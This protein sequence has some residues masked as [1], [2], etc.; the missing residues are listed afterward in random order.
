MLAAAFALAVAALA[1]IGLKGP[2][3][4]EPAQVRRF[5]FSPGPAI[6]RPGFRPIISPDGRFIAYSAGGPDSLLQIRALGD[7]KPSAL[8]DT[9]GAYRPL[10]S[11]D[12][13]TIAFRSGG[14]LKRVSVYGG[15]VSVICDLP[16]SNF[17]GAVWHPTKD[18]IVFSS[19]V[20]P[21]LY[22][23]DAAGGEPEPFGDQDR[24]GGASLFPHFISDG[25][26]PVGIAYSAGGPANQEIVVASLDGSHRV[27]LGP[28]SYPWYDPDGYLLFQSSGGDEGL[29]AQPFSAK[30]LEP[31]GGAVPVDP[32]GAAASVSRD[33]TLV[34]SDA[35]A[36]SG[37]SQLVWLDRTG[38]AT[39][40]IGM[41]EPVRILSIA[42]SPDERYVAVEAVG[43]GAEDIWV[44]DS[45]TSTRVRLTFEDGLSASPVWDPAGAR[46]A[47]RR[48]REGNADIFAR[49]FDRSS[50]AEALLATAR[51]EIPSSFAPDGRSLVYTVS[52]E[53]TRYD[54]WMIENS[55]ETPRPLLVAP[56][57]EVSPA[58]SPDGRWLAFCSDEGGDYEVHVQPFPGGGRRVQVS[59]STGCQPRWSANG[60]ELFYVEG[61]ELHAVEVRTEGDAFVPGSRAAL[62][63]HPSLR[64]RSPL[65]ST[66][67]VSGDGTHFVTAELVDQD[68]RIERR[69]RIIEN[70]TAMLGDL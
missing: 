23:V 8:P 61:D 69:V 70:W 32:N 19:G 54:I 55:P 2:D 47:Y 45:E 64:G 39:A 18:Q 12:S 1:W 17:I 50:D 52:D 51:A 14:A 63:R 57:N 28:G 48:D 34:Y 60:R 30:T 35:Q 20:T 46:I 67:D 41:P 10:W 21:R 29:W 15:P 37:G 33:G 3:T 56:H 4:A 24:E 5:S 59:Q 42:L 11:P 22:V 26:D 65:R 44:Y 31:L 25:G 6:P 53:R 68:E 13:Q 36:F 38:K 16:A 62:F 27:R 66:Y 43:E 40:N 58:V 49:A 9:E 7:E